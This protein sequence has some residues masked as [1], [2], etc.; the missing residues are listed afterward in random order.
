MLMV[1]DSGNDVDA[2]RAAGCPVVVVPYGYSEGIPVQKLGSD[3]IFDSLCGVASCIRRV[4]T[5]PRLS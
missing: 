2:A 5:T 4:R 3:G 1:G